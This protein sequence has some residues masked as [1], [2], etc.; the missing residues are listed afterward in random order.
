MNELELTVMKCI[1]FI[2][3]QKEQYYKSYHKT[4]RAALRANSSNTEYFIS[5]P[6]FGSYPNLTSDELFKT[7]TKLRSLGYIEEKVTFNKGKYKPLYLLSNNHNYIDII[8]LNRKNYNKE[9]ENIE[10]KRNDNVNHND[11]NNIKLRIKSLPTVK[12]RVNF[13]FDFISKN[14]GSELDLSGVNFKGANLSGINLTNANLSN[15]NLSNANLS[16]AI[17]DNAKLKGTNFNNTNLYKVDLR[18]VSLNETN[19][20]KARLIEIPVVK[21][22]E[23]GVNKALKLINN[24]SDVVSKIRSY[25][26]IFPEKPMDLSGLDLRGA[27]LIGIN[28]SGSNLQKSNLGPKRTKHWHKG[29]KVLGAWR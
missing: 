14:E 22:D 17:I 20:H 9:N 15:A 11:D 28:L 6:Y 7:L 16:R 24:V 4:I 10:I 21:F 5:F 27:D 26:E 12:E 18:K 19:I 2:E 13:L 29:G 8:T 25:K 1:Y 3:N 23:F